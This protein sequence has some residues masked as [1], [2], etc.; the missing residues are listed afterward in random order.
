M[1]AGLTPA[2][3]TILEGRLHWIALGIVLVFASFVVRLFQLQ[4]IENEDLTRRSPFVSSPLA[5]GSSTAPAACWQ[6]RA[7]PSV[8]R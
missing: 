1:Q 2:A 7:P 8:W 5:A 6:P 3:G 4:V